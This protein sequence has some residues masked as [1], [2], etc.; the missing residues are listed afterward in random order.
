MVLT[1][2]KRV[3]AA[4]S[5]DDSATP[6]KRGRA[7][8]LASTILEQWRCPITSELMCD[9]VTAA[10]G[11]NYERSAIEMWLADHDSSPITREPI[12]KSVITNLQAK[13][14]IEA[15]IKA[16]VVNAEDEGDWQFRRGKLR[17]AADDDDESQRAFERSI[18][19]GHHGAL[20]GL[21]RLLMKKAAAKGVASARADLARLE[22]PVWR[23]LTWEA[24]REGLRVKL[25]ADRD[26]I[27]RLCQRAA[28]GT[29]EEVGFDEDMGA[30]SGRTGLISDLDH[31][32]RGV[33][34]EF[35]DDGDES[36][37]PEGYTWPFDALLTAPTPRLRSIWSSTI[38][39][40]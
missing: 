26:E 11:H 22:A 9:A 34:I 3:L 30:F 4:M 6:A 10:D 33:I 13:S 17:A 27:K 38:W 35:D 19:L 5:S 24:A 14:T 15:L 21:G 31:D 2:V 39:S 37:E 8:A 25:I 36:G 40:S 23:P 12:E 7:D 28:P 1:A 18:A 32:C 16:G 29:E 20:H